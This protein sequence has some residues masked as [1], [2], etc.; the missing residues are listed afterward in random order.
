M[1]FLRINPGICFRLFL[2]GLTAAEGWSSC[3]TWSPELSLLCSLLCCSL[4]PAQLAKQE[5]KLEVIEELYASW[6]GFVRPKTRGE[7]D[8]IFI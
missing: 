4:E 3:M 2:A 5:I 8:P 6:A 7:E 1:A